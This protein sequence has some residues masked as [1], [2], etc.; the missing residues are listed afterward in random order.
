MEKK[1][2]LSTQKLYTGGIAYKQQRSKTAHH[3]KPLP[4]RTAKNHAAWK[5]SFRDR[6]GRYAYAL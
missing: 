2:I 1:T 3:P 5:K 6:K 4:A